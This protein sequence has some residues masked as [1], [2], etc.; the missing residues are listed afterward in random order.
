[1]GKI[2]AG[3]EIQAGVQGLDEIKKLSAEIEA[4]GTDTGRLAEQ[5]RE[6]ETA[7]ARV[8]A[9]NGLI[10]QYRQL[11]DELGYTKTALKA[12]RDGLAELDMQMQSGATRE[13]KAAYRDLQRTVRRL[14]AEQS[15][16]QGRLKLAAADMRDA[17]ISAKDLAA[18]ERRIAEETGQAAA[19]LEKLTVEAQ[20][21]KRAAEAKAVLGIKTDQARS[22]LAKVK[23]SYA[24]LKASGTLTKRELKQATAAYTAKVRELKAELKGVPSKLNP[25]AA[26]VRGMGGAMLGVAGVGG[27][28]Y[29]V[30]EGLQQVVQATAEYAAIRSRMEYAFGGTEAAGAQMQ[31]VKGLAEELGLEV[32]TLADGY[33]QL[34]SAT[35]NIGFTTGQTQQV[36][37]GVAAAAA[38]MNLSTD[39]TNG[40]LLALSQIAGKGKVSMEELRG[41]LGER[42]IPAMAIAAKSMGVTTAELE[43]MVES[44]ISA[45]AFLPKFGAAMEEAFAGAESAQASVMFSNSTEYNSSSLEVSYFTYDYLATKKTI[46]PGMVSLA[47]T[48]GGKYPSPVANGFSAS[49]IYIIEGSAGKSTPLRGLL[50]GILRI[51]EEMPDFTAVPVGTVYDNLD[52]S[53]DSYLAFGMNQ[54]SRVNALVNLNAWEL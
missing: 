5:S 18:A 32:R 36:F 37:K 6:L 35:K 28:L 33:A 8:S 49:E 14:E 9:Q 42:L 17:G 22:E 1:M 52:A 43:K 39:E 50:P 2:Q 31:W 15:N 21:M 41:Q 45:E 4:A 30:K 23:Q 3:L 29:A 16:L 51:A 46:Y 38:K 11:K 27:G 54:L 26:S 12:A 25:I 7:F 13:Q 47:D 19:K 40:V 53:G 48:Y 44:G 24:E 20:K 10:A 34:A